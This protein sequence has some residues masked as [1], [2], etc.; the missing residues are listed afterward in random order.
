VPVQDTRCGRGQAGSG[1]QGGT[2]PCTSH[3]MA[4]VTRWTLFSFSLFPFPFLSSYIYTY[5]DHS[6]RLSSAQA[7]Q[8]TNL[9][10]L[11]YLLLTSTSVDCLVATVEH[12]LTSLGLGLDLCT[13]S[14][15]F[16]YCTAPSSFSMLWTNPLHAMRRGDSTSL[17]FSCARA[18]H[19]S[20][21]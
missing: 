14:S 12:C 17:H 3:C 8:W 5:K 11:S 6:L 21:E 20:L 19:L 16:S 10:L 9:F 2:Q 13:A 18:M 4:S 7:L 15:I 1:S